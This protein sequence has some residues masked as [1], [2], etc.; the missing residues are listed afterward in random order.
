M[1]AGAAGAAAAAAAA[2]AELMRQEEEEMTPYTDKDL[3][4]GWEFKIVRANSALF[5]KPEQLRA[6]LE[7]ERKGGWTLV[8]KFDDCRIRLKRPAGTKMIQGDFADGYDPY[9]TT[10][11]ISQGLILVIILGVVFG[12][13]A[14]V[15]LMIAIGR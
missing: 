13:M 8:E 6:V 1:S 5:R 9:R 15:F 2:A 7:E 11:G 14:F 3:A 12:L 4:E 10:V